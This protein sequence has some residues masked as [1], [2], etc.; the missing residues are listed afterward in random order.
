M[1]I[2]LKILI[3]RLKSFI[4]VKMFENMPNTPITGLMLIFLKILIARL[5]SFIKVKMFENMPKLGWCMNLT[6]RRNVLCFRS[7]MAAILLKKKTR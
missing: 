1:L 2:F 5:K 4:K 7:S 6:Q 3:A